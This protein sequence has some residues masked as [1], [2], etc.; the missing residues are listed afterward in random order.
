MVRYPLVHSKDFYKNLS[1]IYREYKINGTNKTE[2][3]LCY[4]KKYI[5]QNPQKFVAKYISPKTPY[6]NLL[7]FH[8][9]GAGKTC[10]SIQIAEEWKHK[11][12]IMVAVPASLI[13]NYRS[14]LRSKCVGDTYITDN[15]RLLLKTND[16]KS[17]I[18]KN[19]IKKS[20][21]IINK[22]YIILS[23]QKL[24]SKIINRSLRL[25][26]K[27]LIIDEV[28]NLVSS[29]GNYYKYLYKFLNNIQNVP[30]ILLSGTPMFDKPNEIALTLNLLKLK[31]KIP[32]NNEFASTFLVK[33]TNK[34]GEIL[35]DLQNSK[36]LA[37][38]FKGY[39]SYYRGANPK[40]FPK[41]NVFIVK[42]RM[43]ELQY[44][45][46]LTVTDKKGS[47]RNA[48]IL[49]MPESFF[50]GVRAISN[51]AFPNKKIGNEGLS[52][53]KGKY[54][55]G[56][57]L[58]QCSEKFYKIIQYTRKSI[59]TVFIYSNFKEYAGIKAFIKVLNAYN[60]KDYKHHGLGPKRYA[61]WSGDESY[62]YKCNI[63]NHFNHSDNKYGDNIKIFLG[64]P[65]VKEGISLLR[66]EQVHIMEPYWN[67]SRVD[68][69]I[70]R[71]V[72]YC[73][74]KDVNKSRKYVNIYMYHSVHSKIKPSIDSY[75]YELALKKQILI[76]KFEKV[77]KQS[78]ID[79]QLNK[80][81]NTDKKNK[82]ICEK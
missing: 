5:L 69:V 40:T 3:E 65:S 70:G 63:L 15:D 1:R 33:Y 77:L 42:C 79:C 22:Y 57:W 80:I 6:T 9:I 8:Q 74:H 27:I 44:R 66:V 59:G 61:I 28:Q 29:C 52:S 20:D 36:L 54:L 41:K 30:I 34:D 71:A 23:H 11:R 67:I 47:F 82:L 62:N 48:D 2:K 31:T 49:D 56:K 10:A 73:S 51:I 55:K 64:S 46:Y 21:N 78:A 4:P 81:G 38:L 37:R 50:I 60:Y 25:S 53:F 13:I 7:M 76:N 18:Y 72:R 14:E 12:K 17:K 16:P 19:I 39:I 45:S 32:V 26:N 58:R 75:I 43:K 68:Q 35:Y 24:I